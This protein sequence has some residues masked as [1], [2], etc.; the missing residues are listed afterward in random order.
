LYSVSLNFPLTDSTRSQLSRK[1]ETI[2]LQDTV[3]TVWTRS[4]EY[5]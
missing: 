5:R 1:S 4:R 3:P 2:S